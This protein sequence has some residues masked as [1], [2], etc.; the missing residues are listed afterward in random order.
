MFATTSAIPSY[1]FYFFSSPPVP[2]HSMCCVL[3]QRVP[4]L[5]SLALLGRLLARL[6]LRA[7]AAA[8][9]S[10]AAT[11]TTAAAPALASRRGAHE[12]EVDL[13]GLLEQLSVVGAVD[14]GTG[15]LEGG[16][17]DQRIAL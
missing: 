17:L 4:A 6:G 5:A 3:N 11:G 8:A 1:T 9:S 12:G 15:L 13:D 14:S 2:H 7:A 10:P 16:V